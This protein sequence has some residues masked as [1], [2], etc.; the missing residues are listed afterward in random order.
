MY[1]NLF[2]RTV[3]HPAEELSS[4]KIEGGGYVAAGYPPEAYNYIEPGLDLN[5]RII[6]NKCHNRITVACGLPTYK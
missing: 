4:H 1:K 6:R 3:L 2:R 5:R